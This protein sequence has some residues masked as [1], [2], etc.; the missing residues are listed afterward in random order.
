MNKSLTFLLHSRI[1]DE[2]GPHIGT[3]LGDHQHTDQ[4]VDICPQHHREIETEAQHDGQ[5]HPAESLI[6]V[7][8]GTAVEQHDDQ[9]AQQC[10]GDVAQDAPGQRGVVGQPLVLDRKSV[11]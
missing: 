3:G 7:F 2:N 1:T 5:P 9:Q 4:R 11:V 8:L 10:K 6:L